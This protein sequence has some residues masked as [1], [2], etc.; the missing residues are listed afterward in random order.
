M[1]A[2]R[3]GIKEIIIP[4]SNLR[5]LEEIFPQVKEGITFYPVKR[6]EEVIDIVFEGAVFQNK[7]AYDYSKAIKC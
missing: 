7:E 3:N 4:A 6:I 5:E 2:R 1:A